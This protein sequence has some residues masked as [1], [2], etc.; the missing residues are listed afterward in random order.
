M[1]NH[2]TNSKMSAKPTTERLRDELKH[3]T[4]MV[5][6]QILL[7]AL[8]KLEQRIAQSSTKTI[9]SRDRVPDAM[10]AVRKGWRTDPLRHSPSRGVE[11]LGDSPT[12]SHAT[13]ETATVIMNGQQMLPILDDLFAIEKFSLASYLRYAP[14]WSKPDEEPLRNLIRNIG[15]DQQ[16][17]ANRVG[18]L[19]LEHCG[20]VEGGSFPMRFTAFNDLSLEYLA[21]RVIEDQKRIVREVR[22][23]ANDLAGAPVTHSLALEILGAEQ[24]HLDSLT[25]MLDGCTSDTDHQSKNI[26]LNETRSRKP[27]AVVAT[28][29]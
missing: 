11:T 18:S 3:E 22:M 12:A 9:V 28:A 19:I 15:D 5:R 27:G 2:V 26:G 6:R 1:N 20:H 17:N 21:R 8:W 23:C 24:A 25:K 16:R 14:P 4:Q 7:K 29:A 13:G 10:I